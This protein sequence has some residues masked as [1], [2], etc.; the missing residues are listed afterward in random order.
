MY[1]DDKPFIIMDD[2]FVNMDDNIING[3]K[4]LINTLTKDYQIIYF[5]CH[6]S[7]TIKNGIC[8]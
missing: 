2:P 3:A 1:K 4:A 7:R 8:V 6:P 5:T